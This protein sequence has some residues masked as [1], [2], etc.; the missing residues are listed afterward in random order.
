M[1][2]AIGRE[3]RKREKG[4]ILTRKS[5]VILAVILA[6]NV[7]GISAS[8]AILITRPLKPVAHIGPITGIRPNHHRRP[9]THEPTAR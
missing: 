2:A 5:T 3:D 9:H 8:S 1:R 4:G 7:A 6:V